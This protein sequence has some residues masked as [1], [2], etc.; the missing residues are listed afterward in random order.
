MEPTN[1]QTSIHDPSHSLHDILPGPLGDGF[2]L[3]VAQLGCCTTAEH[4]QDIC[5]TPGKLVIADTGQ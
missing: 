1:I 3:Y 5:L 2:H 4:D